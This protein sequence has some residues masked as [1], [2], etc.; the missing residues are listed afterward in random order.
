MINDLNEALR[1]LK[2]YKKILI[3]GPQ[4]SG[5]TIAS[6]IFAKRLSL[7]C[8]DEFEIKCGNEK[9]F[10]ELIDSKENFVLQCPDMSH[11]LHKIGHRNDIFIVFMM[12]NVYDI[13]CSENRINWNW[14]EKIKIKYE[15][16]FNIITKNVPISVIRQHVWKKY[17]KN[18]VK[19]KIELRYECLKDDDLWID[20]EL[21][22]NF[23]SKQTFIGQKRP[24]RR[25]QRRNKSG[26]KN[27]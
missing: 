11:C 23:S 9:L 2:D 22:K 12:R 20:K 25:P 14:G 4:R 6:K 18:Q 21:R 5:T 16:E 26:F 8:I 1:I 17:Q 3:S 19:N 10:H 7:I 27:I 15:K 13:I 24:Q